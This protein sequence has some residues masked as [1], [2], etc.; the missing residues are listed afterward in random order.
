MKT[1]EVR[2]EVLTHA[3]LKRLRRVLFDKHG[4]RRRG[5]GRGGRGR[6]RLKPLLIEKKF[7]REKT[8]LPYCGLGEEGVHEEEKGC[9][10]A[11]G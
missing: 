3:G 10:G 6:N 1:P 9:C 11:V 5:N 2:R 7:D 4:A 8:G